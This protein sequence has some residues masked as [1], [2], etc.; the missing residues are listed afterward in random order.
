MFSSNVSSKLDPQFWAGHQ[1][2]PRNLKYHICREIANI[3]VIQLI[4][5]KPEIFLE[6]TNIGIADIGLV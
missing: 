4:A 2:Q 5:V 1:Q 3:K 6:T